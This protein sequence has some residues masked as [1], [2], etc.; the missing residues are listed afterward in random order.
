MSKSHLKNCV[1]KITWLGIRVQRDR[2]LLTRDLAGLDPQHQHHR[3]LERSQPLPP[4]PL[5]H[6]LHP[7]HYSVA[8]LVST[9]HFVNMIVFSTYL[10]NILSLKHPL[11]AASLVA[12]LVRPV[13]CLENEH[14]HFHS[15]SSHVINSYYLIT[16]S[17]LHHLGSQP[18]LPQRL[19][20][21]QVSL[22]YF[23]GCSLD[24]LS[25]F[26]CINSTLI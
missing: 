3:R 17:P 26:S 13:I 1:W 8:A 9:L 2:L 10:T 11:V 14:T 19:E 25:D 20:L 22:H 16:Q 23:C 18:L 5:E 7:H 21:R 12:R 4:Q 15:P 24:F 6:L